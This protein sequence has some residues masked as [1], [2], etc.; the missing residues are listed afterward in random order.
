MPRIISVRTN[1]A[2]I[3]SLVVVIGLIGLAAQATGLLSLLRPT[4]RATTTLTVN[5]TGNGS[6]EMSRPPSLSRRLPDAT[7]ASVEVGDMSSVRQ[8]S[9]LARDL[10]VDPTTQNIY[11][12]VPSSAGAGGNS[13]LTGGHC[14]RKTGALMVPVVGLITATLLP[15]APALDGTLA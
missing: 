4:A 8:L 2:R 3:L 12:S 7:A 11:A 10:A 14:R 5:L 13:D 6:A 15:P 1:A 9:F